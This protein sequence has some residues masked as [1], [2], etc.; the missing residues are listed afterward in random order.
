MYYHR[1]LWFV[2]SSF[3][4]WRE[5]YLSRI[6]TSGKIV[7]LFFFDFLQAQWTAG[8]SKLSIVALQVTIFLVDDVDCNTLFVG[9]YSKPDFYV[10]FI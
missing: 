10:L 7:V 8:Q 9:S 2:L 5:A 4:I 6:I 3:F 1:L